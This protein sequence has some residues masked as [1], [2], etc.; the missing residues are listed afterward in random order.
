MAKAAKDKEKSMNEELATTPI[1]D[2][3]YAIG[4]RIYKDPYEAI[5]LVATD[6]TVVVR[7][8]ARKDKKFKAAVM[9]YVKSN[10]L[11]TSV[12]RDGLYIDTKPLDFKGMPLM[13]EKSLAESIFKKLRG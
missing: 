5:S 7:D 13:N 2:D 12:D 10:G 11:E 9:D 1:K 3:I 8:F 4:S 6:Q